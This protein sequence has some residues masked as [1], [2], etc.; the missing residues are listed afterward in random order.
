MV[1]GF[2]CMPA[3]FDAGRRAQAEAAAFLRP[4]LTGGT[5]DA[6]AVR[7]AAHLPYVV[8]L[9]PLL[10]GVKHIEV[11]DYTY[12][13]DPEH[14]TEFAKRNVLY[15]YGEERLVIG[16]YCSIARDTRF[17]M[18]GGNHPMLGVGT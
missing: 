10:D 17:L 6:G 11:G 3:E 13:Q 12:Y 9:K 18:S 5:P 4:R 16:A 7:P 15:A 14:A 8:F 1:H 2:F